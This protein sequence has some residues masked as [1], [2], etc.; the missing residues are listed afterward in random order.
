GGRYSMDSAIGLSTMLGIGPDA[1]HEMLG[2]FHEMDEHFRTTPF[3]RNLPALL[4]LVGLWNRNFL[5]CDT[6]AVLPYDNELCRFSAYLQQLEMESNGKHV[7]LAGDRVG[8][9]TCP[10]IWGEPGTN[11]QHAFFQL[12][13][14]GTELISADFLMAVNFSRRIRLM[15]E[16]KMRVLVFH[17][18]YHVCFT[19]GFIMLKNNDTTERVF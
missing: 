18:T 14:Q 10:V 5:G 4:G 11:G 12:I 13:H 17:G 1:F 3:E 15:T 2:G 19:P 8:W 6:V 7:T 9:D 16:W